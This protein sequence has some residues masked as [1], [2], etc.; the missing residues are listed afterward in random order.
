MRWISHWRFTRRSI[1]PIWIWYC[2]VLRDWREPC[3]LRWRIRVWGKL[4]SKSL[5]WRFDAG[6]R[7]TMARDWQLL[8]IWQQHASWNQ[9]LWLSFALQWFKP[10]QPKNHSL[11][12]SSLQHLSL[13]PHNPSWTN[14]VPGLVIFCKL[15]ISA[16]LHGHVESPF[17]L[18][19]FSLLNTGSMRLIVLNFS[20]PRRTPSLHSQRKFFRQSWNT[21][22]APY[23]TSGRVLRQAIE[24]SNSFW[25]AFASCWIL[26]QYSSNDIPDLVAEQ[27]RSSPEA[28]W[29]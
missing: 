19:E 27:H 25:N 16:S 26:L 11:I 17:I 13:Y 21:F 2:G 20:W 4:F 3:T 5:P 14:P 7:N 8:R 23:F 29:I 22:W 12:P 1:S 15:W 28:W 24:R 18:L 6:A 10:L 9:F